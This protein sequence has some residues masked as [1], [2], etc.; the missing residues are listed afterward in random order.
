MGYASVLA[1]VLF[2]IILAFT[3]MQFYLGRRWVYYETGDRS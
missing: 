2:T 3:M 1:W